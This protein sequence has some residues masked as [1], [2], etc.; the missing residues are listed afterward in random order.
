[1]YKILIFL[2]SFLFIFGACATFNT[3]KGIP[4][5]THNVKI[6]V[7]SANDSNVNIEKDKIVKTQQIP[8]SEPEFKPPTFQLGDTVYI[9]IW[10]GI[11]TND[12]LSLWNTINIAKYK[13]LTKLYIY[14][15][16][17][18]GSV[19][20]GLGLSDVLLAA[21]KD[22]F[23]ITTEANGIVASAAVTVFIVGD[24]GKRIAT[25]GTVF[26][27]H[28]GKMFKLF[29]EETKDDLRAQQEMFAIVDARYNKLI[30]DS[31]NLSEQEVE[32][33]CNYTTWFTA[34]EALEWGLVDIVK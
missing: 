15:N 14:I 30:S 13:K 23:E 12:T 3:Q 32:N 10:S 16:S 20:A 7:E 11:D 6:T 34:D 1:M 4:G 22:G 28:R 26:M 8:Y 27:L 29:S 19:F 5:T 18:G 33:K 21:K 2:V 31:S 9:P 24:K 17:G 25:K